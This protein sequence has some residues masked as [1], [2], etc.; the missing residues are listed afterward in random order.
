M[1]RRRKK[2]Y[3][4]QTARGQTSQGGG[5]DERPGQ[6]IPPPGGDTSSPVPNTSLPAKSPHDMPPG[7]FLKPEVKQKSADHGLFWDEGKEIDLV[8]QAAVSPQVES[9]TASVSFM[10]TQQQKEKL[11]GLGYS[12]ERI[13]VMKP[14][15]A[16]AILKE[17][18]KAS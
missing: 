2:T 4:P 6:S 1:R 8:D 10:I 3:G 17:G 9:T 14:E 18:I 13:R 16:H 5:A 11:R 7:L 15:D 12:E